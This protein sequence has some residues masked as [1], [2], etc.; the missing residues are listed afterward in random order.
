ML[1]A[2]EAL[3]WGLVAEV[4]PGDDPATTADAVRARAEAV[5]RFWLAGA[6]GAY[7]Q[8]KRLIRSQPDRTFAEQ[9]EDEART[10]GAALDTPDAAARIAAFTAS[11]HRPKEQA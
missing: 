4:V 3:D 5:A 10:I 8:A 9:L 2:E 7:G 6:S 1:T 11:S